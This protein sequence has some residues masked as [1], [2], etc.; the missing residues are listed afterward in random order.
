MCD[1]QGCIRQ[2]FFYSHSEN[3]DESATNYSGSGRHAVG[4]AHADSSQGR[5]SNLGKIK[6]RLRELGINSD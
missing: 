4:S 5:R 3:A 6:D 2:Y 1:G